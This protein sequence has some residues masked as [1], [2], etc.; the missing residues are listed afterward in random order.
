M[1][2]K[3][4]EFYGFKGIFLRLVNNIENNLWDIYD[5]FYRF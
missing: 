2:L 4:I 1:L 3:V 5:I